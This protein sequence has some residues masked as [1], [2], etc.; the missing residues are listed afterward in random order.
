MLKE[1]HRS[2][3]RMSGFQ[4]RM[5]INLLVV[6]IPIWCWVSKVVSNSCP[7]SRETVQIVD[8][9]PN[10]EQKWREAAA[11]KNCSA[12]ASQC[13]EPERLVYHCVINAYVNQT[14]EVCAYGRIIVLGVCTEYSF[15]GN[16]I[17]QNYKAKCIQFSQSPCPNGYPSTDAYKYP[18]CYNLTKMRRTGPA[19]TTTLTSV[20]D[21]QMNSGNP[22]DKDSTLIIL[23][24]LLPCLFAM[25]IILFAYIR[26][27][28]LCSFFKREDPHNTSEELVSFDITGTVDTDKE[29]RHVAPSGQRIGSGEKTREIKTVDEEISPEHFVKPEKVPEQDCQTLLSLLSDGLEKLA[30]I[31]SKNSSASNQPYRINL[32]HDYYNPE[33]FFSQESSEILKKDLAEL[34]VLIAYFKK[35]RNNQ[36][37]CKE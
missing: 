6:L 8:D 33:L 26:R 21:T 36:G 13:D 37:I 20:E 31:H 15:G 30:E 35:P 29:D 14:L 7:V 9:C 22:E 5:R 1:N 25:S 2:A 34:D 32:H 3:T 4:K 17:Q 12:Y 10:S 27:K 23:A 28:Q 19:A 24:V 16:A 11:R 18:G